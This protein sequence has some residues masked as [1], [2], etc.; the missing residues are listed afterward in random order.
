MRDL[1]KLRKMRP[2]R[3]CCVILIVSLCFVVIESRLFFLKASR[4][5]RGKSAIV[6]QKEPAA[7][8]S[9]LPLSDGGEN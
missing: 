7:N 3:R 2:A 6:E 4:W 8:K 1:K 9:A 5:S